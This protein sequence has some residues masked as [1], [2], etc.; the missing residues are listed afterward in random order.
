GDATS[1]WARLRGD[2]VRSAAPARSPVGGLRFRQTP[3]A[4]RARPLARARGGHRRRRDQ[5]GGRRRAVVVT[6]GGRP[7]KKRIAFFRRLSSVRAA[8]PTEGFI[9]GRYRV[10]R[11]AG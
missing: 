8:S 4:G 7:G 6:D 1:S 11:H 2:L 10:A 5:G 9:D 3:R